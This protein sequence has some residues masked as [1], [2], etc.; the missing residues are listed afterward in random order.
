MKAIG[1]VESLLR[2]KRSTVWSIDPDAMVYEALKLMSHK[3]VGALPVI[4]NDELLGLVSERDYTR[5]V[6]LKGKSS[7]DTPIR[8]IMTSTVITVELS[9]S[10]E[11]CMQLMTN[12]RIRHLPVVVHG[13]VI[14]I[15]SIGD[16]VHWI[17][18]A[19]SQALHQMEDYIAGKYPG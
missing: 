19:Q 10:I 6:V 4:G 2:E 14:G 17:I 3:N 11:E 5:K 16:V 12:N 13:K 7:R 18:S 8:D 15:I 1:N 9:N